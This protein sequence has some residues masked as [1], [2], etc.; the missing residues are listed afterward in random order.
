MNIK[1]KNEKN[2]LV[3][4]YDKA[5][6]EHIAAEL[7][8]PEF[9]AK[10]LAIRG[11]D[12]VGTAKDFLSAD[13]YC[14]HDPFLLRDMD[15]AVE[16]IKLALSRGEK[17]LI[18]GDYDVDGISSVAALYLFLCEKG[19]KVQYYI[20]DR[21]SEGYGLNSTAIDSFVRAGINLIITVDTGIT[22]FSEAEYIK[23]N[24]MDIIVTDHHECR[25]EIPE[26]ACAVINPKRPDSG[27]PFSELAGVGV[28]FKLICAVDGGDIKELCEKYLDIVALGTVADVMP[29]YG[30]N[31]RIVKHGL[32]VLNKGEHIGI[33][34]L[35]S[36]AVPETQSQA[37]KITSSTIGFAIAP[38]LNA[39]GRIGNV[40]TA[41]ELLVT[42]NPARA[43]EI[44]ETLCLLN[45]ERQAIENNILSEAIEKIESE[46]D[47]END[48]VIVLADDN[49]H[50]GVVGI[51]ASRITEKYRLPSIL[52]TFSGEFGKK[53]S[54]L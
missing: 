37:R 14:F 40:N 16:R 52:I 12:T 41:A 13:D 39:A 25:S 21:L 4:E 17:I 30:E 27:Y 24:G 23:Q 6:S 44:A 51:V 35:L 29:I 22:A 50:Q 26:A 1:L 20:P 11:F 9:L 8:L 33:S 5:I 36:E 46:F 28:V 18:Y 15:K 48:K 34:A 19:G 31:R 45:R 43:K 54:R 49:W 42:E 7:G 10:L 47:F 3:R 2:W 38:R 53:Y 32:A